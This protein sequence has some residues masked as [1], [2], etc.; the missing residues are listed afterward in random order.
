MGKCTFNLAWLDDDEMKRWL[1]PVANNKYQAFCTLCKKTLEL[2]SLGLKA[3]HSHAKSERH[4]LSV[5]GLQRVQAI[6]Q[7]CSP[8]LPGSSS[9]RDSGC[10]TPATSSRPSTSSATG[11]FGSTATLKAEV[12][13]VLNTVTKHQSYRGN[14]DISELFQT[15]FPDSDIAKTFTCGKDKT[16]YIARFGLAEFIKQDLVSKVTGPYVIM[17]QASVERG[18]SVNK[19]VETDNMH[20]E[21]M[22]AHRLVCDYVDLHGGVTKVPLTKELLV[23]V[24]AARSRYRVFLDQQ[25]A[26][27]EGEARTQKRKLAEDYLTDLKKK[28]TTVQEVCTCLTTEADKLAEEAEGKSG[29]KMAQLLS[30]SNALRRASKDKMTELKK[31]EEEITIK[32][33]ELRYM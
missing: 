9:S 17:F 29:S 21:T 32:A 15:M 18:F 7:F 25:R 26:R 14:E 31:V 3:L 19:E 23:S 2:A 11:T 16:S 6:T 33:E 4:Q 22:V 8:S 10:P 24:G 27:K 5:K 12:L 1:K 28:R 30:K 20:E 13:W